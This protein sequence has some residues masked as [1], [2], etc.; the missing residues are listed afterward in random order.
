MT[1]LILA[2]ALQGVGGG[3]IFQMVNIVIG[4]IVPLHKCVT[5]SGHSIDFLINFPSGVR[6]LVDMREHYGES[7][8]EFCFIGKFVGYNNSF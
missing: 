2:R 7:L 5:G 1:W 6:L 8:R 4:D 3:G